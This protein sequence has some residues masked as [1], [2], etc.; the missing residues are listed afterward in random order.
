MVSSVVEMLR[1]C[2]V[3]VILEASR[4]PE[5]VLL[6][7][8]PSVVWALTFIGNVKIHVCSHILP[9]GIRISNVFEQN[10]CLCG[11][12]I[13]FVRDTLTICRYSLP[14]PSLQKEQRRVCTWAMSVRKIR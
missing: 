4:C 12:K 5:F 7:S 6:L 13:L 10:V 2:F 8:L 14:S 9:D 11:G 3:F 1:Y